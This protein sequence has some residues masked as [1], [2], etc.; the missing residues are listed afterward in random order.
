LKTDEL[1]G[2]GATMHTGTIWSR[3]W[4]ANEVNYYINGNQIRSIWQK[5][6][7]RFLRFGKFPQKCV[8]LVTPAGRLFIKKWI[9]FAILGAAFP[10]LGP[11]WREISPD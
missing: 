8:I 11:E 3:A 1:V 10:P 4:Y 9:F 7:G 5:L 6:R 2:P